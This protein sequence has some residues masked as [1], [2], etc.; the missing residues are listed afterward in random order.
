MKKEKHIT[1]EQFNFLQRD[2]EE[3]KMQLWKLKNPPKFKEGDIV[4]TG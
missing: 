4:I 2:L 1:L 3:I